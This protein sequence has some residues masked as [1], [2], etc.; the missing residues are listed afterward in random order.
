[1]NNTVKIMVNSI[2]IIIMI[3][4]CF[5]FF[6]T[7]PFH[8]EMKVFI[9]IFRNYIIIIRLYFIILYYFYMYYYIINITIS[10]LFLF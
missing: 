7:L 5:Y 6:P 4:I 9:I 2:N 3:N 1:M 8:L 10:V